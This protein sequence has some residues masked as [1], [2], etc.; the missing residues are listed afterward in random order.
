MRPSN[1]LRTGPI[2]TDDDV[3]LYR[4]QGLLVTERW[5]RAEGQWYPLHELYHITLRP[6]PVQPG[7]RR[8]FRVIS[9]ATAAVALALM[10]ALPSLLAGL[11]TSLSLMLAGAG[12][13]LSLRRWPRPLMLC[14][15]YRG[16]PVVLFA[17]TDHIE[18]H[19]VCRALRRGV[20]RHEEHMLARSSTGSSG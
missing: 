12:V 1:P 15:S 7:R 10:V 4:W 17:S 9:A 6:G 18:F 13:G 5:F 16:L 11:G 2:R 19:K 14:A 20:E 8:A 3:V